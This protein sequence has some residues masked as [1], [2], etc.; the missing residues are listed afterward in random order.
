MSYQSDLAKYK[1]S[2]NLIEEKEEE[3]D[4]S[5]FMADCTNLAELRKY[6]DNLVLT[7]K[8]EEAAASWVAA[9]R[10]EL[11]DRVFR[12]GRLAERIRKN[13]AGE[14]KDDP[15]Q[16]A[17]MEIQFRDELNTLWCIQARLEKATRVY[18]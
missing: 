10:Y 12:A 5:K 15:E 14:V 6:V 16:L 1:S 2:E 18:Y 7:H 8:S 4:A 9:L 17:L 3:H 13:L 11:G